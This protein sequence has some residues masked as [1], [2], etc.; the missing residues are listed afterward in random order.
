M[1]KNVIFLTQMDFSGK[2]QRDHINMRVEFAQMCALEADHHNLFKLN[3]IS[4]KYDIAILLIPKTK[5]DRD[6]LYNID[7]MSKVRDIANKIVFMQEGPSWIF[8]DLPVLQQIWH[9]NLLVE[10][11]GILCENE[12]DI[13]YYSG[14][15]DKILIKDIPSVMIEDLVLQA[16]SIKKKDKIIIGGNFTRWYGG[17]DSY[18]VSNE[19]N[20]PIFAPSMGRRQPNE[21][22]LVTHLQYMPWVDWI[23]SLSEFKYAV[24]L[25]PTIAAGT[26]SLNC[27][28]L[29]IPCIGY[30]DLDTQRKIHPDLSVEIGNLEKA[31]K[32]IKKLYNDIDFYNQCSKTAEINY[33]NLFSEKIF[34]E[35]MEIFFKEL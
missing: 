26:F 2:I 32:L 9:N 20:I 7:I 24:H 19:L 22:H 27:G 12:T 21:E 28:F 30:I 16:K 23:Y 5:N 29:G 33:N 17:F 15:N 31:K 1:N 3:Q 11:D 14:I 4:K 8:Q 13:Q 10:V 35:K 6:K 34:K 25:M 18:I